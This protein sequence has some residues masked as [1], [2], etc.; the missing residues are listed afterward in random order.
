VATAVHGNTVTLRLPAVHGNTVTLRLPA[1][2]TMLHVTLW[3]PLY[4]TTCST[5]PRLPLYC[6]TCSTAPRLPLYYYII[7]ALRLPLYC[8]GMHTTAVLRLALYCPWHAY[9]C[10]IEA[11]AVCVQS[12]P[13]HCMHTMLDHCCMYLRRSCGGLSLY[14]IIIA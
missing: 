5:A 14:S 4:C 6:T 12:L 13:Y 8:H 9:Y 7:H 1:V 10:C 2:L 11:T 3:L